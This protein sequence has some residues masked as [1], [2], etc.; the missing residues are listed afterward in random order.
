MNNINEF[1]ENKLSKTPLVDTPFSLGE[2]VIFLNPYGVVFQNFHVI[3]FS[4]PDKDRDNAHIY[5]NWD[6]YWYAA[7]D[8]QLY[9]NDDLAPFYRVYSP[10]R[11]YLGKDEQ[12]D[13][14]WFSY[15]TILEQ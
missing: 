2:R 4:E 3:G 12:R 9:K 11:G 13:Y 15:P 10:S 7:K 5:L 8:A 6:S 1:I 14:V